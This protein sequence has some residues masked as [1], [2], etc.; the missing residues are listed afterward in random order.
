MSNPDDHFVTMIKS[1]KG[2]EIKGCSGSVSAV[3]D[4]YCEMNMRETYIIVQCVPLNV[5]CLQNFLG[6]H[7]VL[8]IVGGLRM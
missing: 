2:K 4:D 3:L 8:P 1:K 5:S 7:L 6:V